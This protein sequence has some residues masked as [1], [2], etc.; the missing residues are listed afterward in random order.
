M[1]EYKVETI[2]LV[3]KTKKRFKEIFQKMIDDYVSKGYTLNSFG[4][5]YEFCTAVFEREIQIKQGQ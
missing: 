3:F 2:G 1:K 5:H 4:M